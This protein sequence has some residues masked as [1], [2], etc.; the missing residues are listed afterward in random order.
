M[1]GLIFVAGLTVMIAATNVL[2][3]EELWPKL[4]AGELKTI[5]DA[6]Q[7]SSMVHAAAG[8]AAGATIPRQISFTFFKAP[9]GRDLLI[10]DP[11][12]GA[13]GNGASLFEYSDGEVKPV[14]LSM[15]D[16]RAGFVAQNHANVIRVELE[17]KVLTARIAFADCETGVW[18]YYY[19]FDE[20]DRPVLLSAIDTNCEHLGVRELYHAKNIDL[21]HWWIH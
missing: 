17:A 13:N 3:E 20:A 16:P 18:S 9:H 2:A 6:N 11:C 8:Y 10:I 21:G 4:S 5:E 1:K 12:C 19:R 15:G 14:G 7:V